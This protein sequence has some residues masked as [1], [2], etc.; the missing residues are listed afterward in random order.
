MRKGLGILALVLALTTPAWGM[1]LSELEQ[2]VQQFSDS[3]QARFAPAAMKKITA[4]Q[5]AAMLAAEKTSVF[6]DNKQNNPALNDAIAQ[7]LKVLHDAE[8]TAQ[9]FQDTY[10]DLLK[11]ER[12]ADKAYTYH[13]PPR[14][15]AEP[16][17]EQWYRQGKSA[18]TTA[19]AATEQGDL[20]KATQAVK[21]ATQAFEQCITAAIPG[22]VE[23]AEQ[24]LDQAKDAGAKRYA[25]R[26]WQKAN[27]AFDALE[28]YALTLQDPKQHQ[29]RLANIGLA[30]ELAVYA[31]KIA[32]QAK[33]L[34]RDYGSFE[35]LLL[36]AK[37]NRL[38]YAD[39]LGIAY[40]KDKVDADVE[41]T[42]IL[43][44]IQALKHENTQYAQRIT[45]LQAEYDQKL[46]TA[47]QQQRQQDQQAFQQTLQKLKSAYTSRLEQETFEKKR[48]KRLRALFKKGEAEIITKADGGVIIRAKK[49]QFAPNSSKVDGKY[50]DFLARIKEALMLYPNRHITIEGH[51]DSTGDA[52]ANRKLS[53]ARAEAVQNFLIASGLDSKRIKAVGYGEARPIATNMYKKGRAMNRRIDIVIEAPHG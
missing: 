25:P 39:I 10:P 8:N 11:L 2:R 51:T 21:Q 3:G 41:D 6:D 7:T 32:I 4:Y 40:D 36:D 47:L 35:K 23:Q 48:L 26:T 31:Q 9:I 14:M 46:Q 12:Q 45:Q 37:Q 15:L 19:I 29:P 52:Q 50:F 18:M 22:M 16:K 34:H 43:Q 42:R 30:M 44:A 53:L 49:I 33:Y 27:A 17:V 38:K 24:A 28:Q 1:T 20:N 13:H 5:G